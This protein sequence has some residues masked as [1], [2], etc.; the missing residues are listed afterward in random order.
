MKRA[1]GWGIVGGMGVLSAV[2]FVAGSI[3]GFKPEAA[4]VG[5]LLVL[6]TIVGAVMVLDR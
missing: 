4:A 1:I 3:G 2:I 5:S 6:I